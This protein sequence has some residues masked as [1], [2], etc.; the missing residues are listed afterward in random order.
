MTTAGVSRIFIV[1]QFIAA[2]I[3]LALFS[4]CLY[5]GLMGNNGTYILVQ[6]IPEMIMIAGA[7]LANLVMR[8]KHRNQT[9]EVFLIP[10]FLLSI[11]LQSINLIPFVYSITGFPVFPSSVIVKLSR[12]FFLESAVL[13]FF[14]SVMNLRS[15]VF[16]KLGTYVT[17]TSIAILVISFF[18]PAGS[19][20]DAMADIHNSSL[21]LIA[22]IITMIAVV[23]YLFEFLKDHENYN[24]KHFITMFLIASGEFTIM[25]ANDQLS[26]AVAGS[27]FYLAG[28]IMLCVVSPEGY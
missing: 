3:M 12:F 11:T 22:F 28:I 19:S 23:T 6:L 16:T 20:S 25:L 21:T 26:L 14:A 10:M 8:L 5:I 13:L 15:S 27:I 17:F 9:S 1:L 24:L 4:F 18:I 7:V 2:L